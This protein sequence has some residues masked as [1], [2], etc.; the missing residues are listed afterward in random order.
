MSKKMYKYYIMPSHRTRSSTAASRARVNA[1]LRN[2]NAQAAEAKKLLNQQ[3]K[4]AKR[5]RKQAAEA[6][7]Q[8]KAKKAEVR[9]QQRLL[10]KQINASLS[11]AVT[12]SKAKKGG[13]GCGCNK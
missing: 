4:E 12:R 5:L 3:E 13:C 6:E 8:A 9:K 2:L 10:K 7:K 11:P 1:M